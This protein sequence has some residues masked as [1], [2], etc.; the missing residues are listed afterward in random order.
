[1]KKD[2][3]KVV[4]VKTVSLTKVEYVVQYKLGDWGDLHDYQRT[5]KGARAHIKKERKRFLPR[6]I[7]LFR[8]IKRTTTE[9]VVE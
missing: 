5:E 4:G 6:S 2:E 9:E 1:V 7:A 8:L 3:V